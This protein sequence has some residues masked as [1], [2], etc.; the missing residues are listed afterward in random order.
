VGRIIA[1]SSGK[2]GVGKTTL[3]ANLSA[4][5]AQYGKSVIAVDANLTTSNLGLHLGIPLYPKTLQDVLRGKIR[6][7]D[8]IYHHSAGFKVLPADLSV[9]KILI[10]KKN[11]F[12]D[13]FYDLAEK[14][15]FVII[16]SA[17]G[18]GREAKAAIE[19]ADEVITITNP[20]MP[21]LIDALKLGKIADKF[22]TRNLGVVIN[23]VRNEKH[24]PS[25]EEIRDFLGLPLLGKIQDDHHVRVSIAKKVPVVI[26]KPNSKAAKQIKAI[27]ARLIG[28][29]YVEPSSF[30][31]RLFGW[32][33]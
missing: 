6:I 11:E 20:E 29:S 15:D 33:K 8:A 26:H 25:D 9:K 18:L 17:A 16:D 22:G 14:V 1:I 21:A 4:A 12:M 32:L 27:A 28:E 30:V 10:P 3:V 19:A 2:G 13:V 23:R 24:E 31:G 7:K 5:L